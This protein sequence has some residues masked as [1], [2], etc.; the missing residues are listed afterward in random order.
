MPKN[1]WYDDEEIN[2]HGSYSNKTNLLL[3]TGSCDEVSEFKESDALIPTGHV[4]FFRMDYQL[5]PSP[6][7][8]AS[9]IQ[10]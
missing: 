9:S 8:E 1:S 4:A 10:N 3:L 7:W 2:T 6:R 5:A